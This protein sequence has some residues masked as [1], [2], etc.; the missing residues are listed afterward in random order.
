[1]RF[2]VDKFAARI[3]RRGNTRPTHIS[4]MRWQAML[5]WLEMRKKLNEPVMYEWVLQEYENG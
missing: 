3:K 1:M 4:I 2:T 5:K